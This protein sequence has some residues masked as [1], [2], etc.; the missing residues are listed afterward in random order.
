MT[1]PVKPG[2]NERSWA[3]DVISEINS[4]SATRNR[5]VVRAGGEHTVS[6]LSGSLFP[7]VLLFG[8]NNGSIVQQGWE[9]KMPD[10]SINDVA[11]INNASLKANR[12]GLNSFVVWNADEAVLYVKDEL[13]KYNHTKAWPATNIK[14]RADVK[15]GKTA[16]LRLLHHIL[17]DVNELLDHGSV[18]G[19]RPD[20][21][22][23]DALFIDYLE[24]FVP[25]LSSRIQ[26]ACKTDATFS[27]E[28]QLWWI[29]N[30]NEYEGCNSFE[31]I[32]RVNLINWINRILFA[33]Y[34]KRFNNSAGIV[35]EIVPGTTVQQAISIFNAI[36]ASCDFMNVF[37]PPIGQ[38]YVDTATWGGLVELN[39][40][41]KDFNLNTISQVSFHRI[42][43]TALNYSKKKMAGQFSTPKPLADLLV[44]LTIRDRT[45]P[46]I[47]ATCGTGTIARAAYE[48]KKSVG[49]SIA[50]SLKTTWASDKFAFPLQLCSIALSDPLGIGEVIQVFK[51]DAFLLTTGQLVDFTDPNTGS[52]VQRNLPSMHAAISNLPFVRFEDIDQLNPSLGPIKEKLCQDCSGNI[53]LENKA[54]LYAYLVLKLRELV[55]DDDGRV[56]FISSNSWLG[57]NWGVQF[58]EILMKCFNVR[59]VVISG[60]GR[61]FKNADV[62]T[63][64]VVLE[65]RDSITPKNDHIDFISTTKRIEFWEDQY[66]GVDLLAAQ[67]L[68]GTTSGNGYTKRKYTHSEIQKL[69]SYGI[70]W[71]A[72]FADLSWFDHI[73]PNLIHANS[74]F[75]INRGERRGWDSLFY[76][77]SGHGIESEYIQPV[78]KTARDINGLIAIAD[79]DA[80]CCSD[81]KATLTAKGKVGALSWIARFENATNGTGKP[82]PNVLAKPG[83]Q[84][85]EMSAATLADF[86]ISMNPDQRLCVHRLNRRSFVNQRLIR[87]VSNQ[88]VDLDLCHALMNSVV[89]MF[90]IESIGFGR[91]LGV[92][93]INPTKMSENMRML[94]PLLISEQDRSDILSAFNSLLIRDVFDLKAELL[95]QDRMNF[96]N[97]VLNAYGVAHLQNQIYDSLLQLFHIRQTAR[98]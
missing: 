26:Q 25:T 47:D 82:L 87:F 6:G 20:A 7:D 16:W 57:V 15:A 54:D 23:S 1:T 50:D 68:A 13:G 91:G 24:H 75:D 3:I 64:I 62:V 59:Q 10:T 66:N 73:S 27:A 96:D 46:F 89:G 30:V 85:Y 81:D 65:K 12:L 71:N 58:K 97:V 37:K 93:D 74:L 98:T 88:D 90:L 40:F 53:V 80:F 8:D 19:A 83:C 52:I 78:L 48:L 28:L 29:E 34:L 72:L 22:I 49:I 86:V 42:I 31:A 43:D 41:L 76:P 67:I 77:T 36:T 44:R 45:K 70:G 14:R 51:H 55:D 11:L 79:S 18:T 61:W 56:G 63:T 17:D 2:Y 33:H 32:A 21:V 35:E 95:S 9:L 84:W 69:V 38:D 5:A 94:N 60:E 4:Y 39:C 92:L